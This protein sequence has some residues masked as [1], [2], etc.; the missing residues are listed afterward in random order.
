MSL[1][2]YG[3]CM[4]LAV[5]VGIGVL[6]AMAQENKELVTSQDPFV[7]EPPTTSLPQAEKVELPEVSPAIG[8]DRSAA[9]TRGSSKGDGERRIE[10]RVD[11]RNP[12][13]VSKPERKTPKNVMRIDDKNKRKV[14]PVAV[15]KAEMAPWGY[16]RRFQ[17]GDIAQ[18][19]HPY[20]SGQGPGGI[21]AT[22]P[23][24]RGGFGIGGS[25]S[26]RG[27]RGGRGGGRYDDDDY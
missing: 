8:M 15:I 25:S 26:R 21:G 9:P 2:R 20:G 18:P 24:L 19:E 11:G 13:K 16:T 7:L 5:V 10:Q 27:G 22:N 17:E 3:F 12:Q 1:K 23:N 14:Q 6:P 4:M